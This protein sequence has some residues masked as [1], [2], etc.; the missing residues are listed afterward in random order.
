MCNTT[1]SS[2]LF[3]V[4]REAVVVPLQQELVGEHP[5]AGIMFRSST[6]L[7][8]VHT[9]AFPWPL[10]IHEVV[11]YRI[12]RRRTPSQRFSATTREIPSESCSAGEDGHKHQGLPI[13]LF[14][15]HSLAVGAQLHCEI[16]RAMEDRCECTIPL[17]AK[18]QR[19]KPSYNVCQETCVTCHM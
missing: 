5:V 2:S 9:K 14:S 6:S 17:R 15:Y 4:P 11:R 7:F 1:T 13:L 18:H 19:S 16:T 12:S 3:Q 10:W 8:T